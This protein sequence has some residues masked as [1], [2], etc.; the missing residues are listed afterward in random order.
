MN[1]P[2]IE[3]RRIR[4]L[5]GSRGAGFE[6]SCCQLAKLEPACN[7]DQF[8]RKGRG[9]DAGVECYWRRSNGN[10]I[11][12]QA[13]Y[14]FSWTN[15]L[16]QQLN[17]SISKAL[18]KHPNLTEY[19]VCLP[20]DLPDSR[21]SSRKSAREKWADW[22]TKWEN[23]AKEQG[24]DLVIALWDRSELCSRLTQNKPANSG[25]LHYWFGLEPVTEE[26]FRD[27]F[28]KAKGSLGSRYTPETNIELT[29]QQDL[30]AFLRS[31]PL[32]DTVDGWSFGVSTCSHRALGAIREVG[33]TDAEVHSHS[34]VQA[35]GE[36]TLSLESF[37]KGPD[38]PFPVEAWRSKNSHCLTVAKQALHWVSDLPLAENPSV[39]AESPRKRALRELGKLIEVLFEMQDALSSDRWKLAN[40]NA[41]LLQGAAGV[42]K[43]HLLADIVERQL[44]A[45]RPA[46]LLLGA[47]FVDGE[48]WPQIRDQL[49][50]P[51]DEQFNHFLGMLDAAGRVT[52]VKAVLCVDA[53][54]ERNGVDVWPERLVAFL[55]DFRAFPYVGVILSCRSDYVEHLIPDAVGDDQLLRVD[56]PG[57]AMSGGEAA[58]AYLDMRGIVR[59]GAPNLVPEFENPLFLKTCCD[60]LE[61]E[62]KTELPRGL[63]GITKIFDYYREA[64]V[65]S[66]NK[67]M[68]LYPHQEIVP[69]AINGF[70]GLL[71][72]TGISS[73]SKHEAIDHFESVLPSNG[74]LTRSLL[75]QL[76]SEGILTVESVRNE[77]G[78][79]TEIVRFTFERFSDHM[80]AAHLLSK[81][82]NV[83]RPSSSFRA[84]E[85]L[86]ELAFG[87]KSFER[88]G[89]IGALAIQLPKAANL[90]IL[91]VGDSQSAVARR[92][93]VDSLL[94]REQSQ[95][96]ENTLKLVL[97]ICS[98]SQCND[99]LISIS[100]EPANQFNAS[101]LHKKLMKLSM[102]QRDKRWSVYL[103]RQGLR[104][105]V[106]TLISWAIESD[107]AHIEKDRARLAG[108]TLAWF[109]TTSHREIRDKATKGL[110]NLL[111][112]DLSLAVSLLRDFQ[113]V[114][115]LYV[116]ERLLAAAYGA[117]LQG[118]HSRTLADFAQVVHDVI[119]ADGKPPANALLRDHA[120][121]I[122]EYARAQGVL[123]GSI[124]LGRA[125]PPYKSA[126]PIEL[127]PDEL[128]AGYTEDHGKGPIQDSIVYSTVFDGDFARYVVDHTLRQWSP[129]TIGTA[130]L[131]SF[132]ET[133]TAWRDEFW[134]TATNKQRRTLDLFE[135]AANEARNVPIHE[136]TPEIQQL[137]AAE[138]ALKQV[139]TTRDWDGFRA[140]TKHTPWHLPSTAWLRDTTAH[141]NTYWARRWICKRAHDLGWTSERFSK[142]DDSTRNWGRNEHRVERI[143]KKYQWLAFQELLAR[144]AD[145]LVFLGDSWMDDRERQPV[146][147]GARQI[148]RR[149][150][151]PSLLVTGTHYDGWREWGERWWVPINPQLRDM[152]PH[153]RH[154]WLHSDR[155]IINSSDLIEL[156]DPA[157]GRQ[158]LALSGFAKWSGFGL[159]AG[160][161]TRRCETW[162]R[163]TCL[164]VRRN[165]QKRIIDHFRGRILTNPSSLPEHQPPEDFYLGEYLWHPGMRDM[166]NWS[167]QGT[168]RDYP[169]PLRGAT[170]DYF[171]ESGGYDYSIDKTVR[172]ETPAPW[173]AKKMMLRLQS[174]RAL[175]YVGPDD[176]KM[177]FD[178]SVSEPG[179][180]AALVDREAFLKILDDENL[181]AIWI[182]AGEK[183]IYGSC[184]P[185]SGFGGC[186]RH[187]GIYSF[188]GDSLGRL[189]HTD[190]QH[191]SRQ[192]VRE[193]FGEQPIPPGIETRD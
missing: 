110:A 10:E 24:R 53:I 9:A 145:N 162:F 34:M 59:P 77:D 7:G 167:S 169:V 22:C 121:G 88:A 102:P 163:L 71:I 190:R 48:I 94:W 30:L 85:P 144:M 179:P 124:D 92:A 139:L 63:R 15:K 103:A 142:F 117:A 120:L 95:F 62:N 83:S 116:L 119:F 159:H 155:D 21:N 147:C 19:V 134:T 126:W 154:A 180:A 176:R 175:T 174:G 184:E 86:Y 161:K 73:I 123:Q 2:D 52:G 67:Q 75:S 173:L 74:N 166:A 41:V 66:L 1:A 82:L 192:Q 107:L 158:W 39:H 89:I 97:D 23:K 138:K 152:Q 12:W 135:R 44:K 51:P 84:G 127:V 90:E 80:I 131:P 140:Q 137:E 64:V 122:I 78:S 4:P 186:M 93:F 100:T 96:T 112:R 42:G 156:C 60:S 87:P 101:F 36:L 54:N 16:R 25:H 29:I 104:G 157:T 151:D 164:L 18:A 148:H 105:S 43:S 47:K 133:Y 185:I 58:R 76:T 50:R 115:D 188:D 109:L 14:S 125:R 98:P 69:K 106:A 65:S 17:R 46:I 3:F 57:F 118:N 108:T 182:V 171:C 68:G 189:L 150:I 130:R 165:H 129:A 111:S 31:I 70:V 172:V 79:W 81:H 160:E 170:V 40:A 91:D 177:F 13:K 8:F 153:E 38:Q 136:T 191:P 178:P 132:N 35:I 183:N 149:D 20:F 113:E 56:H 6:E 72:N 33:A 11:G 128:I 49:G 5:A 187:T 37:P 45:E 114:D 55:K 32:Q 28:E 27:Q 26:W 168:F 193:F 146:Y 61:R 99:I 141:F 181:S 143:G